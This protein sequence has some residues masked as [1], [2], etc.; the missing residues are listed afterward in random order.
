MK[1]LL[2]KQDILLLSLSGVIDVLTELKDPFGLWSGN[3]DIYRFVPKRFQK[4]DYYNTF[5]HSLKTGYIEKIIKEDKPYIRLTSKGKEK[6]QRDFSL[7]RFQNKKWDKK[8]RVVIFDIEEKRKKQ[9]D[10]LREKLKEL[11]FGMIQ[12]SVW[13]SPYDIVVDFREFIKTIGL[14]DNVFVMEVRVLLA[15]DEKRLAEKIWKLDEINSAYENLFIQLT[16]LSD[17]LKFSIKE[18][19]KEEEMEE[20]KKLRE[21]YLEILRD[22]PCLPRELLPEEWFGEKVKRLLKSF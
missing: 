13:I 7:V 16:K 22:D 3:E 18:E 11:G 10:Q 12:E 8:W 20:F 5:Y 9:R 21:E 2:R 4:T 15:G 17:R 19:S 14:E 6:I 1:K